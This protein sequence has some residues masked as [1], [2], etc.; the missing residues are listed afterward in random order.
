MSRRQRRVF[1]EE[2]KSHAV[3]LVRREG[4]S[5]A[6]V[7]RDLDLGVGSLREWV[8]RADEDSPRPAPPG[9]TDREK[10]RRLEK[11]VARLR[12]EREILKKAAAFFANEKH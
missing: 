9:E 12:M 3:D 5:L 8:F 7:A 11:E 6:S 10:V 1:S 4:R 2:F